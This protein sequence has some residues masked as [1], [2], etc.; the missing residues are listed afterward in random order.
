MGKKWV[1]GF[2]F[3]LVVAGFFSTYKLTESP[4]TW[5]DEGIFLQIARNFLPSHTYALRASPTKLVPAGVVSTIGFPL[6][7]PLSIS[8]ALFGVG[9]LQARIIMV[10]YVLLLV[11]T[12]F[13]FTK[14]AWNKRNAFWATLL[15]ATHAPVYGNGKNV[16]GEVPGLVFFFLFLFFLHRLTQ[17]GRSKPWPWLWT[18]L[19][20]GIFVATKSSFIL[21]VPVLLIA[22]L[23][24]RKQLVQE[25]R[26]A[27]LGAIAFVTPILL[28][29]VIQFG[30]SP[31]IFTS[32]LRYGSLPG[33]QAL[34]GLTLPQLVLKNI[35]SFFQQSTP[36]YVLITLLVWLAS[37]GLRR[38]QKENIP[39]HEYV[40][41]G[42]VLLSVAYFLKMPGVFR[43]LFVAQVVALPYFVAALFSLIQKLPSHWLK[44]KHTQMGGRIALA[45][46]VL[47]QG[48]QVLFSSW[49][50]KAYDETR[51]RELAAYFQ[52]IDPATHVFFY[53]A[54]EAVTFLQSENY[55]Q[56]FQILYY[57]DAFGKDQLGELQKGVPD[58]VIV[59]ADL[60]S[61][62]LPSLQA[63]QKTS[64]LDG[65]SYLIFERMQP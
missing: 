9:I 58:V 52:T 29:L 45:I 49:V 64:E 59:A 57:N 24:F 38:K 21:L 39:L 36:A 42:F 31:D 32:Y 63:Y 5:F 60:E 19:A 48:Y 28:N 37:L 15:I 50:A 43:Y 26:F 13:V 51:S 16:L 53:H 10:G 56:Y 65:G 34:T 54:T 4:R 1:M 33:L 55:S 35:L 41:L 7:A 22:C 40:S 27:L 17:K 23:L 20:G 6:I 44:Q 18:G 46:L 11:F 25:W 2:L 30:I 8:F 62:A 47:F 12:A 61:E 3:C 14:T